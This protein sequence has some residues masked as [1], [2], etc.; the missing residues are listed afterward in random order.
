MVLFTVNEYFA[1]SCP[2]CE[3]MEPVWAKAASAG[4][5]DAVAWNQKECYGAGWT[6]GKDLSTCTADGVKEFPTIVMYKTG[7][8]DKWTAPQF[9]GNTVEER[10]EQLLNFVNS[11]MDNGN[12]AQSVLPA[13]L[14]A[15]TT[16]G[17]YKYRNFI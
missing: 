14:M 16:S 7:T 1:K 3:H 13:A 9:D 6:E 4:A 17:I 11:H 8:S 12:V 10:A 2:H 5:S 15:F